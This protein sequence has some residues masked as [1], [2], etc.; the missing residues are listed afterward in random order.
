MT[1]G[2]GTLWANGHIL[3][4]FAVIRASRDASFTRRK[5]RGR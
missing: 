5:R 2:F 4:D 1:G 3:T